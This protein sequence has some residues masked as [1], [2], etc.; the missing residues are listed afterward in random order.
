MKAAK[1]K[2]LRP[3]Q[4]QNK[5]P[6]I[7]SE[8]IPKPEFEGNE[9]PGCGKLKG[10]VALVSGGDSGIGR[11]VSLAFAKE[12]C[13]IGLIYFNEHKDAGVTRD[14]VV[15]LNQKCLLLPGDLSDENFCQKSVNHIYRHFG[16][17]NIV[18]NNAAVQFPQDSITKI[19]KKQLLKTFETNLFSMFY[20]VKYALKYLKEGSTIINTTSVTAYRGSEN[21]IDYSSTKG[22]IVSFS[23]NLD[24]FV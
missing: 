16:K 1:K 7:E 20:I 18:V 8:M 22:A 15:K 10:K 3:P 23:N 17:L 11:A 13:D 19:S 4:S 14:H 21:L 9:N 12:G 2:K 6:G 24:N 5:Q